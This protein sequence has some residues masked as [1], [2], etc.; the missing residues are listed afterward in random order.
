MVAC[1]PHTCTLAL[2]A[3]GAADPCTHV[4]CAFW[5]EGG[6]VVDGG[7][8]VERLGVDFGG[9][10][11]ASYLLELRERLEETRDLREAAAMRSRFASRIGLEL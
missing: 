1:E 6:A 5:E 8:V 7:C 11:L 4:R 10:D 3:R 2:A 9:P